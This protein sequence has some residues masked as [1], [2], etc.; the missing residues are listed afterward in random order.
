MGAYLL[1][2]ENIDTVIIK[3]APGNKVVYKRCLFQSFQP[4]GHIVPHDKLAEG[5][6]PDT[7]IFPNFPAF[8][9]FDRLTED[10]HDHSHI[11]SGVIC[12]QGGY[13]RNGQMILTAQK[14][15][16]CFIYD[17]FTVKPGNPDPLDDGFA[18]Q[19]YR[20]QQYGG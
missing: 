17:G 2:R 15:Q 3:S 7:G 13:P 9:I 5:K 16:Q 6:V 20:E 8:H 11:Y 19:M 14:F 10:L 18:L 4:G 12:R 1:C